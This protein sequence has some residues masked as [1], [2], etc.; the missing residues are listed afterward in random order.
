[1][2]YYVFAQRIT[3]YQ[4]STRITVS[5]QKMGCFCRKRQKNLFGQSLLKKRKELAKLICIKIAHDNKADICHAQIFLFDS[6]FQAHLLCS[7]RKYNHSRLSK[8]LKI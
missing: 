7:N 4:K 5:L 8:L 1:M 3:S 2:L 6:K